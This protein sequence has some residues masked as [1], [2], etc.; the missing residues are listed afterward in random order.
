MAG[1]GRTKVPGATRA[2]RHVGRLR[3]ALTVVVHRVEL[4][5]ATASPDGATGHLHAS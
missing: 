3:L 5:L 1:G 4:H 2:A